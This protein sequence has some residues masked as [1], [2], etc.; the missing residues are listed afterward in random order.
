M[1]RYMRISTLLRAADSLALLSGRTLKPTMMALE[2]VASMT[3]L[4]LM[5]PTAQWMTLTRTSSLDSFSRLAL[6]ASA[7][8]WTSALTMMFRSFISPCLIWLNR[9]SR[10]TL[11]TGAEAAIFCSCLRCSTSSRAMRSSATAWKSSPA[12]GTSPMPMIS[13]GTEGPASVSFSPLALVMART[14]PT[15]VPAMIT[16]PCFRVPF[17]TSRVATG[18]RPLS[19]R[20]SMTAPWAERLGLA[21]SSCISAVRLTISSRLSMPSPVL[22]EMGQMMV[23]PPHS[24]GTSSYLVSCSLMRSGLASGLSILLM[25][26][27]MG[28]LAALAWLM[29]STVWGMMPSSAATTRMAT[30]VIMAPRARMAV[31][32]SWPGVSRKV[33]VLPCT[34]T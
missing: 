22:A 14:R 32:A 33:M 15:A 24:S 30:S 28:M 9:S 2:V 7:E 11:P 17:C 34:F 20:A 25:A 1:T 16:S 18:P 3:S 31:K 6:T 5:A 8:P 23:S 27:M 10:L 4:S 13:T 29:D 26:T 21:L 12:P 19:S